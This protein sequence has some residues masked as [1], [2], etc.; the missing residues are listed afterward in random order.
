MAANPAIIA[1]PADTWVKVAENVLVGTVYKRSALPGVYFQTVRVT[2]DAAPTDNTDAVGA[3]G[4]C[5]E[6]AISSDA[7]IDV[8]VKAIRVAGE[9]RV[10]L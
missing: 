10:D 2:G 8:Y 7:P 9:I 3:F 4:D 6:F 1:C 5:D